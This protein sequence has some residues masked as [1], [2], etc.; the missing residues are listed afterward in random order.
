[1]EC[2]VC[3]D[4][5]VMEPQTKCTI[6][7]SD[8]LPEC[9]ECIEMRRKNTMIECLVCRTPIRKKNV[10]VPSQ[11]N[12]IAITRRN[13]DPLR[14]IYFL[15]FFFTFSVP[16]YSIGQLFYLS[17]PD[18]FSEN[19]TFL[20]IYILGSGVLCMLLLYVC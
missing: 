17:D 10:V 18:S 1:M 9:T 5:N 15:L 14:Y 6:C 8:S 4:H 20:Q 19:C 13:R 3:F 7:G 16:A 12:V 2:I 11:P